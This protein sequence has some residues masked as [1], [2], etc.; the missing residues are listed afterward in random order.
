M[1]VKIMASAGYHSK[2]RKF[3]GTPAWR[4]SV[5]PLKW[6]VPSGVILDL[7]CGTGELFS[8]IVEGV[9]DV[10]IGV[11]IN[12]HNLEAVESRRFD[13]VT[14][15]ETFETLDSVGP[16]TVNTVVCTHAIGHL[17]PF[18][19]VMKQVY[20]ALKPGGIF[21]VMAPNRRHEYVWTIP[22]LFNGY[23]PDKTIHTQYNLAELRRVM[24]RLGYRS[25]TGWHSN[26]RW[27]H[28]LIPAVAP[29]IYVVGVKPY[30]A[31]VGL[32][33]SWGAV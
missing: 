28:N 10:Y 15:I 7:G 6:C 8:A 33:N 5:E 3:Q 30:S 31:K 14:E 24:H 16:A 17:I 1:L 25:V 9:S 21:A 23:T 2:V 27:V 4:E 20:A 22:N 19:K 29:L 13:A 18:D 32:T 12:P 26:F 11:D